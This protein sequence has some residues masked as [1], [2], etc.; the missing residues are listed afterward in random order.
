MDKCLADHPECPKNVPV[1][2]PTRLVEVS[3]LGESEA[4]RLVETSG[5][6]GHY[7]AL[8]YCWG[9]DQ[10]FKTL[11]ER[12]NQYKEALPCHDLPQTIKDAFHVARG[13]GV[14]YIWIDAFCII[15]DNHEDKQVEMAKMMSI[16]QNTQFTISAGSASAVAEGFLQTDYRDPNIG[17]YYH[18][19]RVDEY[20]MGSVIITESA[21]SFA[22]VGASQQPINTRGWTLQEAVLTPDS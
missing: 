17:A 11:R 10:A 13:M 4:A 22:S 7:C 15:Q 14:W 1:D 2:L 19:L 3:R 6:K 18:P 16:Y 8:S 12:Y 21:P 9:G 5:Q 20:T